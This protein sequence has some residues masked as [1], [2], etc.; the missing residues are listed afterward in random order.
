VYKLR[1]LPL[2]LAALALVCLAPASAGADAI[3]IT[4]GFYTVSGMDMNFM[5]LSNG[6][7]FTFS[8]AGSLGAHGCAAGCAPGTIVSVNRQGVSFN[9]PVIV[10]NGVTYEMTENPLTVIAQDLR[11]TGGSITADP[12]N[13]IQ[14]VPFTF[15]G[16]VVV[17]GFGGQGPSAQ[18]F[19]VDLTGSGTAT[20]EFFI[21]AYNTLVLRRVDYVF[22]PQPTP[23][24]ATLVL[25]GSGSA[26]L[27]AGAR[28]RRRRRAA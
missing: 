22:A 2:S 3:V 9:H 27:W 25:F 13:L 28:R 15:T 12:N 24:P 6:S 26:A 17:S 16:H 10:Y 5:T 21:D 1:G 8:A 4:S 18:L 19:A 20:V 7:N 23:E 11:F 14:Q